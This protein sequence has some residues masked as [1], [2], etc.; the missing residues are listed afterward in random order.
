MKSWE[1]ATECQNG[2]NRQLFTLFHPERT[3]GAVI[4]VTF[5]VQKRKN[6]VARVRVCARG[7]ASPSALVCDAR[8]R[9][10]RI[11]CDGKIWPLL[12]FRHS[13][14]LQHMYICSRE[15]TRCTKSCSRVLST[16][17]TKVSIWG[18]RFFDSLRAICV[19]IITLAYAY[20]AF[21]GSASVCVILRVASW[22]FVL[23][24]PHETVF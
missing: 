18:A 7:A 23:N 19:R 12:S 3:R 4:I 10:H 9:T 24:E 17:T 16:N 20:V 14:L 15:I 6:Q 21:K 13:S 8:F 5:W 1:S 22:L 2:Q 11:A